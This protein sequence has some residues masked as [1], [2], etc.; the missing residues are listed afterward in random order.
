MKRNAGKLFQSLG[1]LRDVQVIESWTRKFAPADNPLRQLLMQRLAVRKQLHREEAKNALEQF[2]RKKWRHLA[3]HLAK[4]VRV[5]PLDGLVAQHLALE[6]WKDAHELHMQASHRRSRV[7]W[8]R[9][10]IALKR[11]RYCAENFLPQRYEGWRWS[12]KRAQDL[13]GELHDLDMLHRALISVRHQVA[14]KDFAHW[15]EKIARERTERLDEYRRRAK[16]DESIFNL[17]RSALPHGAR[18]QSAAMARL[19]A[20][21]RSLGSDSRNSRHLA[22]LALQLCDGLSAANVHEFFC[23]A[24]GRRILH[25]AALLHD[26]GRSEGEKGRHKA[27]YRLIRDLPPPVGWSADDMRW[28]ALVA[29]YHR[30]AEPRANHE[31]FSSLGMLEQQNLLWLAAILRLADG[32]DGERDGRISRLTVQVA[33]EALLIRARGYVNDLFSASHL[34]ERKHLLETVACRPVIVRAEDVQTAAVLPLRTSLAS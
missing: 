6:Y 20:W 1:D 32:L 16:G 25:A 7:A 27:S 30:G 24:R 34:A 31:G 5:I 18:E 29:R 3:V 26:V 22:D 19:A 11:L 33:P 8:H 28:I 4:R 12:L 10:R 13:L 23:E 14:A 9:L 17:C 21:A 2:D 15:K